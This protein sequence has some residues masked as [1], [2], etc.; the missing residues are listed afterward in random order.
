MEA[1]GLLEQIEAATVDGEDIRDDSV[2]HLRCPRPMIEVRAVVVPAGVVKE[3]E[4]AHHRQVG[5]TVFSDVEAK[6]IDSSPV[7]GS[8]DG[9]RSTLK[10][11]NYV[12]ADPGK[13]SLGRTFHIR[14]S[15]YSLA[16]FPLLRTGFLKFYPCWHSLSKVHL[17]GSNGF[18]AR[19][20]SPA[21]LLPCNAFSKYLETHSPNGKVPVSKAV[22]GIERL[23]RLN[24]SALAEGGA[25]KNHS[26]DKSFKCIPGHHLPNQLARLAN[27]LT[28]KAF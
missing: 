27:F 21:T 7:A 18:S 17:S 6:S 20:F 25:L 5:A 26:A 3:G 11:G 14:N 1:D 9:L 19:T 16:H 12:F 4:K 2:E 15:S 24:K 13:P 8:V 23:T 10:N 22:A 28:F